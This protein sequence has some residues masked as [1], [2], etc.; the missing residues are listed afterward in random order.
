MSGQFF[1]E[2]SLEWGKRGARNAASRGD[3]IIIVDVLSFSSTVVS[4]LS[5]GAIIFPYPPNLDG[6]KYAKQ[7]GAEYILGRS[8][9]A[10][11]GLPTLSPI[12]FDYNNKNRKYVLTSLNGAFCTW[13]ASDV[14]ALLIGSLLN[15]ANVAAVANKLSL[16]KKANITVVA[17]GELWSDVKEHEDTLRPAL[18]DYLGAGAILSY[19][20]GKKSPDA[21][22]S[23]GAFHF[24]KSN[25]GGIIWECE[26]GR[27]LRDRGFEE[28][29]KHCSRLNVY[30]TVPI[31]HKDYFINLDKDEE[32][33]N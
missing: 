15:A 24:S 21:E 28:D 22:V 12:S 7:I 32:I 27:E 14:P 2:C 6:N 29:V 4:A 9:A 11:L 1:N 18:E 5:K 3:I 13:I 16:E 33:S 23:I 25:L 26:S 31:L 30:Q 10:Q 8:E 19:L 20:N 17:C